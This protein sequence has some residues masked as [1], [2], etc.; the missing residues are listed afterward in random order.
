MRASLIVLLLSANI[1]VALAAN[2]DAAAA[3]NDAAKKAAEQRYSE[4][5]KI[6]ADESTAALRMQCLRDAKAEYS[7]ALGAAAKTPEPASVTTRN[8]PLCT[9]CGRVTAVGV[10]EKAGDAGAVGIIAGGVAGALLGHQVGKGKGKDLA[11]IAG[12]AGGAYAGHKIEGNMKK[13]KTWEV[14]VRFDNGD[15]RVYPFDHD[16]GMTIGDP[17]R[18]VGGSIVRR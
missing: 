16:P 11:T 3:G 8:A 2:D 12:A 9:D 10:S 4:D 13:V 15:Q 6:C 14:S 17:V 7:R 18:A 1:G 5:R